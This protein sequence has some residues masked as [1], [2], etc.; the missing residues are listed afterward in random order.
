MLVVFS[1]LA[2]SS[3]QE[4]TLGPLS[5]IQAAPGGRQLVGQSA[6]LTFESARRLLLAEH[7]PIAIC[8]QL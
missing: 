7:S 8:T 2:R 5:E 1:S 3:M 4:F 6:N